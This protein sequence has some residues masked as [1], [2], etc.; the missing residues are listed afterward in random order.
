M[1]KVLVCASTAVH[2]KN[3]HLPYLKYFRDSGAEVHV[4]VPN[5]EGIEGADFLHAIP[6]AKSF[7]SFRNVL[8]VIKLVKVIRAER[9]DLILT[10]TALAAAVCRASLMIAGKKETKLIN[11]VHG[12]LFWNGCGLLK[13]AFYYLPELLLRGVTDCI[14]TMNAE[15]EETAKKLVRKGG[16]VKR[17]PGMGVD[18]SRFHPASE[19]E[20]REARKELSIPEGA[21][22]LLYPA[23]FSKR[24]NHLELMDAME[25][26]A[27]AV[28]NVLL[29]LC[30]TGALME[31]T[32][33]A[34]ESRRL[35]SSVRFM[36]WCSN[37]EELYKACDLAVSVSKSEGLPFNIIEAEMCSLPVV[38]SRIRGHIDLIEDGVS[39]FLYPPGNH[40]AMADAVIEIALDPGKG[41]KLGE[42]GR[43][44]ARRYS[45]DVAL[46]ENISVYNKVISFK[47]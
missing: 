14:I 26:I 42:S 46:E 16:I 33:A 10:H 40:R 29:L 20:K 4:A 12:Y 35:R 28:P 3:F 15:D 2:I 8:A 22:V 37:M 9:F 6:M 13:K 41:R 44:N 18:T 45:L 17:V 1:H 7:L 34:A 30:G 24:K 19:T 38:A 47:I 36:G 39:G 32:R 21:F 25:I 23:E 43:E 31:D 27:A 11:T 5:P